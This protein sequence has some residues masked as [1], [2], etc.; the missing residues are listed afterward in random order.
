[1]SRLGSKK[2]ISMLR[3]CLEQ[4]SCRFIIEGNEN[5]ILLLIEDRVFTVFLK[6][7]G[8]VCYDNTNESTRVQLPRR[9]YFDKIKDSKRPFLLMGFDLD[10]NV[11]ALWNPISTKKRLNI[12]KN[13]SFYCRLCFQRKA[14]ELKTPI[15]CNLTNGDFVWVLPMNLLAEFLMYIEDFFP[16]VRSDEFSNSQHNYD[17]TKEYEELITEDANDIIDE[18]GKIIAIK[19][20]VILNELKIA[21]KSGKPFAEYDVLYE[22]YSEIASNMDLAEWTLLLKTCLLEE[23]D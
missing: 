17:V 10:N 4:S 1:M 12:K 5:P 23:N 9:P 18:N 11:F 22:H 3:D 16:Q 19:N 21:R 15:R 20:P 8:D 7:I 14:N 13:S 6:P 2:I